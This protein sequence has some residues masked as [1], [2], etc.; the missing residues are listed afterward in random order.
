[1]NITKTAFLSM[2]AGALLIAGSG[3]TALAENFPEKP[4]TMLVNYGAGGGVDMTARSIQRFLPDAL[5][6][7]VVV[8][9]HP[10]AGGKVGL[11]KFM[12]APRDGYTV[13]TAFAPATTN[14][15]VGDPSIFENDD[16]AIINVQWSDEVVLVANKETGWTSLGDMIEAVRANP[17]QYSFGSSGR[18]SAGPIMVDLLFEALDLDVKIVPYAGGGKTRAAIQGGHVDMIAGGNSGHV[19]LGDSVNMIGVFWDEPVPEWP[20]GQTVNAQLEEYGVE[21]PTAAAYRFHAVHSDVRDNHPERFK[22]LVEA[23]RE[24]TLNNEAFHEFADSISVRR[25]WLGPQESQAL[26][27]EVDA[28]F[29]DILSGGTN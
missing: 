25:D 18:G 27:N 7:N 19:P 12:E 8:E 3:T 2:A 11:I 15:R 4:V 26:I 28:R 23:F 6:Q 17:G 9:N 22:A 10:G 21:L 29:Y 20:D 24:T 1:M 14:V 5:G 13:L 16:L